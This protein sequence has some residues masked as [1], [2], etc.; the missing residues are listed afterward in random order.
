MGNQTVARFTQIDTDG[1]LATI[2]NDRNLGA[3]VELCVAG[4]FAH[5]SHFDDIFLYD[6]DNIGGKLY[7]TNGN[8]K[9]Q[10]L[11]HKTFHTPWHIAVKGI[12]A[13]T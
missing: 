12:S 8:G 11:S 7:A 10:E 5:Q 2:G 1:N 9:V 4:N 13:A 6:R 3:T